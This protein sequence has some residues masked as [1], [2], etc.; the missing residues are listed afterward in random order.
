MKSAKFAML[1]GALS[2]VFMGC[3][4]ESKVPVDDSSNAKGDK[5]L[6]GKWDEKGS[7]DYLWTVTLDENTYRIEKKNVKEG[8]DPTIYGAFLSDVGGSP[9]LNVWEKSDDGG[10][11]KYY[12]YKIDK[13]GEERVT[14][15]GMTENVTEE[16]ASSAE[17][18]AF[19]KKYMDLS[20][21]WDKDEE[22]I[23]YKN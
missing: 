15:K 5:T 12:I 23:F 8:G 2:L 17:L 1:F 9:F 20:F 6:S 4:Y 19:I 18:K 14:L 21:F 13:K 22:K 11:R 7:E 16:F 3:P 10:D